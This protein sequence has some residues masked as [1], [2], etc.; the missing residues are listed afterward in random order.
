MTTPPRR[1]LPC[2]PS[3]RR[4]RPS[5]RRRGRGAA[6]GRPTCPR[7]LPAIPGSRSCP[8]IGSR[9][10]SRASPRGSRTRPPPPTARPSGPIPTRGLRGVLASR[11]KAGV[12]EDI[13]HRPRVEDLQVPRRR[14]GP[15]RG[16][17]SHA[18]LF[19]PSPNAG[20]SSARRARVDS[21][22]DARGSRTASEQYPA[23]ARAALRGEGLLSRKRASM[24]GR[25]RA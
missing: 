19:A 14:C 11:G 15:L 10:G 20:R 21:E 3:F 16:C 8:S 23:K 6:G 18:R 24:T 7:C 4:G 17:D 9:P 12:G 25:S 2:A 22:A 1:G 13:L 5:R